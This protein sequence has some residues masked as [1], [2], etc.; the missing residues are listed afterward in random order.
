LEEEIIEIN[1]ENTEIT[2]KRINN[3][4]IIVYEIINDNE[5]ILNVAIDANKNDTIELSLNHDTVK[6]DTDHNVKNCY[7]GKK[8]FDKKNSLL[9]VSCEACDNWYCGCENDGDMNDSYY[10][11]SCFEP[12]IGKKNFSPTKTSSPIRSGLLETI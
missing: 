3:N 2:N 5:K 4:T 6:M 11:T 12:Q 7:L 9:W 1:M 10:C 8:L